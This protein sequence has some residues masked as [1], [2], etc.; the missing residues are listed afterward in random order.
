M[1]QAESQQDLEDWL[2]AIR[3]KTT[4]SVSPNIRTPLKT[5]PSSIIIGSY[6]SN[7]DH[8]QPR[9]PAL[10]IAKSKSTTVVSTPTD[11]PVTLSMDSSGFSNL[12][13][14]SS[15]P[16][17]TINS[18]L[19]VSHSATISSA[20]ATSLMITCTSSEKHDDIRLSTAPSAVS[21]ILYLITDE[22]SPAEPSPFDAVPD[23]DYDALASKLW[24]TPRSNTPHLP[25][26][27]TRTMDEGCKNMRGRTVWPMQSEK[28]HYSTPDI[29]SYTPYLNDKNQELRQLFNGVSREEVVM[30]GK[31]LFYFA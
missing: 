2:A 13:N 30:D 4:Q 5:R 29:P 3:S 1:L 11:I 23:N 31:S 9:S 19:S 17:E 22:W 15:S 12:S 7:N 8:S 6:D 14:L 16:G 10:L 18:A 28:A 21:S 20:P 24:G 25:L 26:K 27:K